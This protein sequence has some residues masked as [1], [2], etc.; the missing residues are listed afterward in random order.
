[1]SI[2]NSREF[3]ELCQ[4]MNLKYRNNAKIQDS[5]SRTSTNHSKKL[6]NKNLVSLPL[7]PKGIPR[8]K[9]QNTVHSDQFEQSTY[10]MYN[11]FLY[12]YRK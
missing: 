12:R 7:M 1:M 4:N 10:I 2:L 3:N 6:Q 11:T 9:F 8:S 5:T